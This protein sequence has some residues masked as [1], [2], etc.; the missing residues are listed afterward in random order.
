MAIRTVRS[1]NCFRGPTDLKKSK[2]WPENDAYEQAVLD[3]IP[4]RRARR[5]VMDVEHEA[6]LVGELLQLDLPQPDTRSIRAAAVGRDRQPAGFRV[7]LAPHRVQPAADGGDGK[8]SRIAC[9]PD[10]H[11]PCI[12]A[13]VVHAIGHDLAEL[14]VLEVMH[15]HASRITFRAIV[16]PPVLEIAD[17]SFIIVFDG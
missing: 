1:T 6:R 15:L 13:N 5:I 10:A 17:Q 11:P 14:L 7:A 8:L 12:G 16:G 9:D 4:L 2:L 3:L